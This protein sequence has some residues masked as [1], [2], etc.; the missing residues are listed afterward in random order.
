MYHQS[1]SSIKSAMVQKENKRGGREVQ[2]FENLRINL[3]FFWYHKSI[4]DNFLKVILLA[5]AFARNNL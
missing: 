5:K 1:T 3:E 4:F 2:K